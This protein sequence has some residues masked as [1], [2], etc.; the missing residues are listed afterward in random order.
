M[1]IIHVLYWVQCSIY[2]RNKNQ[3]KGKQKCSI[4]LVLWKVPT[5]IVLW[6]DREAELADEE[7]TDVGAALARGEVEGGALVG[8]A[9]GG[10]D[11]GGARAVLVERRD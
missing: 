10:G 5:I 4:R 2:S 8:V 1:C 7:F 3:S 11:G 6:V 9:H